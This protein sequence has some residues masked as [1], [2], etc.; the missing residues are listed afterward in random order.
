MIIQKKIKVHSII[1]MRDI[2]SS[3]IMC[4]PWNKGTEREMILAALNKWTRRKK[5]IR[6]IFLLQ[7]IRY[8]CRRTDVNRNEIK[9]LKQEQML[10]MSC[11]T[12]GED[13]NPYYK[14]ILNRQTLLHRFI[15]FYLAPWA[16]LIIRFLQERLLNI[17][18]WHFS[19]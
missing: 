5:N 12:C 19:L 7:K 10:K 17:F 2:G 13:H 15:L 11:Y 16:I 18:P 4:L 14:K 6:T 1:S 8:I 9:A 3:Y